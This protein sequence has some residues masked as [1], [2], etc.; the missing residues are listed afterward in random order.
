MPRGRSGDGVEGSDC[1]RDSADS[2]TP[3]SS[4]K[5]DDERRWY[6]KMAKG[7]MGAALA[8]GSESVTGFS[9]QHGVDIDVVQVRETLA[10]IRSLIE[11]DR[12]AHNRP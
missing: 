6:W 8:P 5:D 12:D 10:L 9:N 1:D 3:E 4:G 2:M 11:H 7:G